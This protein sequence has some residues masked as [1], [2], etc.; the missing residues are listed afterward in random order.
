MYNTTSTLRTIELILGL[1]PMT[2]FDAGARPMSAA[3]Q[4]LPDAAAYAA[5]KPRIPLEERNPAGSATADRSSRLDFSDAD[6][7][8]DN[9][10][11]DILWLAVRGTPAAPAPTRSYFAR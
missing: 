9:E 2:Q 8:D 4:A 6:R 7:I 1:N 10:L 3:F 5:Q 11:N